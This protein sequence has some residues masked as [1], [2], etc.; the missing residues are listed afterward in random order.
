VTNPRVVVLGGGFAR[1]AKAAARAWEAYLE[2]A[3]PETLRAA[4]GR[5]VG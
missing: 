4:L 2:F 1:H 5:A 3:E